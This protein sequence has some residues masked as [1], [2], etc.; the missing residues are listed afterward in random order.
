MTGHK[1]SI[2]SAIVVSL[3]LSLASSH[4]WPNDSADTKPLHLHKIMQELE[5]DMQKIVGAI[6]REDWSEVAK[7]APQ[8]AQHPQPPLSEKVRLLSYLG[9]DASR[10]KGFDEQT[11]E[12]ANAM[13]KAAQHGDGTAVIRAFG[14]MQESCL[15]CH[16]GFRKSVV[17]H[18]YGQR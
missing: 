14:K 11:H 12:A 8:V 15:A 18:F 10:F 1:Y 9:T 3:F 6:S 16:Q 2:F 5:R 7:F 4:A 13:A 17:E